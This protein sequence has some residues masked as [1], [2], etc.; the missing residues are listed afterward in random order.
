MMGLLEE[1][2]KIKERELGLLKDGYGAHKILNDCMEI[3]SKIIL[4]DFRARTESYET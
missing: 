2:V 4:N 1:S 3:L